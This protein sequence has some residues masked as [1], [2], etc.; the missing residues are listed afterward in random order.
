[1]SS[2]KRCRLQ[3]KDGA[4]AL[5]VL[6]TFEIQTPWAGLERLL[7][8]ALIYVRGKASEETE[9]LRRWGVERIAW[10]I[11]RVDN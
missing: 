4:I 11:N 9:V 7:K 5:G 3:S 2:E 6:K 8:R 1:M 10:F